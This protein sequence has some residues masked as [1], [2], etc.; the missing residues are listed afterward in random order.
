[1]TLIYRINQLCTQCLKPTEVWK[2]L[3]DNKDYTLED[4]TTE[5]YCLDCLAKKGYEGPELE[6]EIYK[7]GEALLKN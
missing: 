1:M 5:Y 3:V 4:V 6:Y 2:T 7:P